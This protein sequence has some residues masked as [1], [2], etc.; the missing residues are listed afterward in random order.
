MPKRAFLQ[1]YAARFISGEGL[2]FDPEDVKAIAIGEFE[3]FDPRYEYFGGLDLGM[4]NDPT[5]LTIIRAPRPDVANDRAKV[6]Y[7]QR[8]SHMPVESQLMLVKEITDRY[9]ECQLYVDETGMG[10][11]ILEQASNLGIFVRGVYWTQQEKSAL[12]KNAMVLIE[13]HAIILPMADLAP[14]FHDELSTYA[15]EK[16]ESRLFTT[17]NAPKGG[18][19]DCIASFIMACKWIRAAG[20]AGRD[21]A[22]VRGAPLPTAQPR[23][24]GIPQ[25]IVKG[26]AD[27]NNVPRTMTTRSGRG[28]LWTNSL[29]GGS[30]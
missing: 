5:V 4:T 9:G 25:I 19:D 12:V 2:V 20:T 29:F 1:E 24:K 30:L 6:V 22:M 15:W 17:S 28:S 11:P 10:K 18:T 23:A 7:M 26:E 13:K 16:T 14:T 3:G 27:P 8:F 21:R